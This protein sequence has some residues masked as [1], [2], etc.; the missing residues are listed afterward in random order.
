MFMKNNEDL[1][2]EEVQCVRYS[3]DDD[4]LR[5]RYGRDIF[6]FGSGVTEFMIIKEYQ[7]IEI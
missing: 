4:Y 5:K 7:I 6:D 2:D 1:V 3:G